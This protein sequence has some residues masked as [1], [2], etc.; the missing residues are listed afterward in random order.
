MK[1]FTLLFAFFFA[2]SGFSQALL[3][4]DTVATLEGNVADS[5]VDYTF[6]VTNI[7]DETATFYWELIKNPDM[8][9]DWAFTICDAILCHAEFTESSPCEDDYLNVLEPG[10]TVDY[11]KV[12]LNPY[13]SEGISDVTFR[14]TAECAPGTTVLG[15]ANITFTVAGQSNLDEEILSDDLLIYPNPTSDRFLLNNDSEVAEIAVFNIVGKR[16]MSESHRPGLSHD[17]SSL[18]KG[19]YLVRMLDNNN[20]TLKV[21]RLTKE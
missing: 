13:G 18:D 10:Q 12:G 7:G 17:V 8:P 2:A 5:H 15:E 1:L 3:Q 16:V 11:F 9:R 19:I 4:I 14:M 21:I 6:A 20:S